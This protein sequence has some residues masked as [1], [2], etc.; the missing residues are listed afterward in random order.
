MKNISEKLFALLLIMAAVLMVSQCSDN[1]LAPFQPEITNAPDNFQ[2]QATNVKN[3]TTTLTYTWSNSGAR[4]SVDHSTT[5]SA[6]SAQ[7]VIEE[8]GGATVYDHSLVPSLTDTTSTGSTG[9]WKIRLILD[10]Y[11]GTL[12]FRVQKL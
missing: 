1:S 9:A 8:T 11:S 10:H 12:N 5:T 6:G 4:A 7:L 3:R 2:L